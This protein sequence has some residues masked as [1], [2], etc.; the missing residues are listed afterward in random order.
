MTI[1]EIEDANPTDRN[2]SF[3]H[4]LLNEKGF[5]HILSLLFSI[6]MAFYGLWLL[7]FLIDPNFS[8]I[9]ESWV[10]MIQ[11][12]PFYNLNFND[13]LIFLTILVLIQYRIKLR[14]SIVTAEV[15]ILIISRLSIKLLINLLSIYTFM[16]IHPNLRLFYEIVIYGNL[17]L[18]SLNS[19]GYNYL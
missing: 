4:R 16:G 2:K 12:L 7:L 9:P 8:N 15:I 5:F 6:N 14:K 11:S 13:F 18:M 1:S 10:Y 19:F 17:P 3:W